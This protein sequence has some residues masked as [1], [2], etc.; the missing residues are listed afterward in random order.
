MLFGRAT[1][2]VNDLGYRMWEG[3]RESPFTRWMVITQAG[4][5]LSWRIMWLRR[6]VFLAFSPV[7]FFA[8]I[9]YLF[10]SGLENQSW[11]QLVTANG[12]ATVLPEI[13][14]LTSM[15]DN[16][17]SEAELRHAMWSILLYN[18][19]SIPQ[20]LGMITIVA[21]IAPK[22]ISRDLRTRAILLYFS[23]PIATWEY[24]VGKMA[25]VWFYLL[26]ITVLPSL[27]VYILGVSMAPDISVF[28]N[29]W[30]L[31]FRC[32]FA[33]LLLIVPTTMVAVCFSSMTQE[34]RFALFAWLAIWVVGIVSY[35]MLVLSG[36]ASMPNG[37]MTAE[38][39]RQN[40]DEVTNRWAILSPFH[41]IGR[42][43]RW[44]FF[45]IHDVTIHD[46]LRVV[47]VLSVTIGSL[48]LTI[49]HVRKPL[50]S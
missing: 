31:P 38:Q 44:V 23:R 26:C 17:A 35:N 1:L 43:Q 19:F 46:L 7:I 39:A 28:F 14:R 16:G 34:S 5:R 42:I 36:N 25:I 37:D 29:T 33:A 47:M 24:I 9:V 10:E 3:V 8:L 15:V 11:I 21:V 30:D 6:V 4:I 12:M 45:G 20:A 50:Q 22:L 40:Y 27:L 13:D 2:P 48:L 18:Y 41:C 32:L 49:R